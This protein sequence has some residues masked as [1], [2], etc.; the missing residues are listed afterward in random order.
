MEAVYKGQTEVVKVL[1]EFG[2]DSSQVTK[3]NVD[4]SLQTSI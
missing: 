3:V 4:G 1:L 2:V